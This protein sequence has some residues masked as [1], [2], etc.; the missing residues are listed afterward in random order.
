MPIDI[1]MEPTVKK[2]TKIFGKICV[3]KMNEEKKSHE[4]H[5]LHREMDQFLSKEDLPVSGY[6][7][8]N[9]FPLCPPKLVILMRNTV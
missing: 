5:K 6:Y 8:L 7:S 1:S 4:K 9:T 3:M 2:I